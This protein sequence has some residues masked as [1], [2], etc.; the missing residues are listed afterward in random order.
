MEIETITP[1]KAKQY[2]ATRVANRTLS[3]SKVLEYGIAMEADRWSLNGETIKFDADGHLFDGQHRLEACILAQ[4]SFRS[5]VVRGVKDANAM[6]TVD[7]GKGRS[8]TDVWTIAGHKSAAMTSTIALMVILY[9]QGRV[10][11]N[12]FIG[13]QI[14]R[15]SAVASAAKRT[16]MASSY[17]SKEELLGFGE[18]N[19]TRLAAAAHFVQSSPVRKV[20]SAQAAGALYYFAERKDPVAIGQFLNDVGT[21]IGL[22]AGDPALV[23]RDHVAFR[24]RAGS[25]LH[26]AY[27]F[28]MMIKAW[29]ARRA[30]IKIKVL[31]VGDGEQ[32][33]KVK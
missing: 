20:M 27:V 33:P 32:F 6:S 23:L 9:E 19:I 14:P 28:G 5:Y 12:G 25:K 29:N 13:R 8:H 16:P 31:R 10:S 1:A 24:T 3:E 22:A 11:W 26:R 18:T 21:G 17:V 4:V 15:T 7:T 2:L 30:G